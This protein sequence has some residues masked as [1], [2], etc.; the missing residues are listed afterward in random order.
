MKKLCPYHQIPLEQATI[1]GVEVDYCSQDYGLW[2][3]EH[4]LQE[5]KR[6]AQT[7]EQSHCAPPCC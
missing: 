6:E 1:L 7:S 2:F 3:D 4:E 5:A